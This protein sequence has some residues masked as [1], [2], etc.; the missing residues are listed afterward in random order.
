ML[1]PYSSK[2][3]WQKTFV[4]SWILFQNIVFCDITFVKSWIGYSSLPHVTKYLWKIYVIPFR[5]TKITKIFY[6]KSLGLYGIWGT[7]ATAYVQIFKTCK[8]RGYHKSSIFVILFLRITKYPL[9]NASQ[10]LPMNFQG[11]KF[12]ALSVDHEN[13]KNYIPQKFVF[14]WYVSR[15]NES[16]VMW[17]S[18]VQLER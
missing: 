5:I 8:F 3:L 13:L 1:L 16:L 7:E 14:V 17:C 11:W 6:L 10:S 18:S 4:I 15:S 9:I 12:H 2:L